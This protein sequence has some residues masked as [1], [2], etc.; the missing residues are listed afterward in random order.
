MESLLHQ[1]RIEQAKSV[2]YEKNGFAAAVK[3]VANAI[4]EPHYMEDAEDLV[5]WISEP[6]VKRPDAFKVTAEERTI[7]ALEV[8]HSHGIKDDKAEWYA[9][10]HDHLIG[11]GWWLDIELVDAVTGSCVTIDNPYQCWGLL[12]PMSGPDYDPKKGIHPTMWPHL[13]CMGMTP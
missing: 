13:K 3:Q 10:L 12:I 9:R 6:P 7:V 5:E 1:L 11:V 4:T 8:V 2:G